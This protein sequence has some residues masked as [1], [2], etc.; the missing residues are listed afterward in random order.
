MQNL[1]RRAGAALPVTVYWAAAFALIALAWGADYRATL[2]GVARYP[3]QVVIYGLGA[4]AL[5]APFLPRSRIL[6]Y[7]LWAVWVGLM[8]LAT[9]NLAPTVF[10]IWPFWVRFTAPIPTIPF[11]ADHAAILAALPLFW[12]VIRWR[13]DLPAHTAYAVVLIGAGLMGL[14][15][16][17]WGVSP[18]AA[19]VPGLLWAGVLARWPSADFRAAIGAAGERIGQRREALLW[20]FAGGMAALVL[21]PLLWRVFPPEFAALILA[22]GLGAALIGGLALIFPAAEGPSPDLTPGAY[23]IGVVLICAAYLL[24]SLIVGSIFIWCVNPDGIAYFQIAQRYGAGEFAVRGVWSPMLSWI[25]AIPAAAGIQL[26]IA[27]RFVAAGTGLLWMFAAAHLAGRMGATRIMRL[28]VMGAVGG[29][30]VA[31]GQTAITPDALAAALITFYLAVMLDPRTVERPIRRGFMAGIVLGVAYLAKYFHFTFGIAHLALTVGL[32][33][34]GGRRKSAIQVGIAGLI[35]L[36]VVALPWGIALGTRYGRVTFTTSNSVVFSTY[37]PRPDGV[38]LQSLYPCYI[39]RL[40]TNPPDILFNTEDSRPEHY[41]AFGWSP[42]QSMG[43]FQYQLDRINANLWNGLNNLYGALGLFALGGVAVFAYGVLRRG[44]WGSALFNERWVLFSVLLYMGAYIPLLTSLRYFFGALAAFIVI[45]LLPLGA[46]LRGASHRL[47]FTVMLAVGIALS[48]VTT[49]LRFAEATFSPCLADATPTLKAALIP[50]FSG[51]NASV[52][53]I[54][55]RTGYRTPGVLQTDTPPAEAHAQLT[56]FG[57]RS[58]LVPTA[59]RLAVS[60]PRDYGWRVAGQIII[61]GQAHTVLHAPN[62]P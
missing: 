38:P 16:V 2:F 44:L 1:I 17:L 61:C 20:L 9:L 55:Y 19:L 30:S 4:V 42:L 3:L 8:G 18:Y 58:Y 59:T 62:Q 48:G 57:V 29:L 51:H 22:P 13:G 43:D 10:G 52:P 28:V 21:T 40:C 31:H 11:P 12:L 46:A 53:Y 50:P 41:P 15:C 39:S 47:A 49:T 6:F 14:T 25:L 34:L 23:R 37:A 5:L 7:G 60:L 45:G 36:F 26:E 27:Y 35:G 54:A 33:V 32:W 24:L 56:A